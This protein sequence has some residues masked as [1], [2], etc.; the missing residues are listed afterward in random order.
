[1]TPLE[2]LAVVLPSPESGYYCTAELSTKKKEHKFT[3]N[4]EELEQYAQ[5]WHAQKKDVYFALAAFEQAGSREADNATY[6]RSL[7]IDMDG[8]ASKKE[9]A[10]SLTAFMT[11]TGLDLLGTPYIVASGGGLHVY[12][13]FDEDVEISRWK[14]LAE[15]LKRLCKQEGMR[16]DMAVTA[17]AARVLRVPDT[18]NFKKKYETPR[19]VRLLTEG[20]VFAFND[21][22]SVIFSQLQVPVTQ[23]T[24]TA[25]ALPGQRPTSVTSSSVPTA[26]IQNSVTKFKKILLK[27]KDGSGCGQLQ[28][29]IENASEDDMEPIWRGMLSWAKVCDD[30]PKACI[31]LS[32][33]HPYDEDRMNQKLAQI[34]GPYSCATMD[35]LNPGICDKCQHWGKITN[36]LLWGRDTAVTTEA[37]VVE[38]EAADTADTTHVLRPEPPSGFAYGQRGGVFMERSEPDENG[39][40]IKKQVMILPYDFFPVDILRTHSKHEVHFCAV[41]NKELHEVLLPQEAMASRSDTIKHLASANVMASFGMGNDKNLYDYVRACVEKLSME[42][43]PVK[44][45]ASYGWQDDDT[46]V[47]ANKIFQANKPPVL[48]PMSGLEN[49]TNNTRPTGSLDAWRDVINLMIRRQLWDHLAVVLAGAG[50]ALMRFTGLFGATVHCTSSES[51]TG[52]SFA[53]DTAASIW[54]HPVHYRT[55]AGTSPV[56][57]QQRLGLLRSLPLVTD[58]ITTNNRQ[59]FE[60]F[61]AFLFSMSEGRGKERM[62]SGTNRERVNLSVWASIALMSSNRPA[63]D[64][65]AGAR[66]H[67]SEGEL[68]R[69]IE[70]SMDQ[71]LSWTADEI[72]I[73]KSLQNNYAVAGEALAQWM[74]DNVDY[75]RKVVPETVARM[76]TEYGAPNDER[77]WMATAGCAVAAGIIFNSQHAGIVDIPLKEIISSYGRQISSLRAS[78]K[79]GKRTAEDVLNTYI[80]EYQGKFVI[81]KFGNKAHPSAM[82]GDGTSVDKG[83]TRTQ[84]MGR[85]EHGV[86]EGF[87]DF[88]IEERLMRTFCSNMSFSYSTFKSEIAN[89]FLTA[90]INK[91]DMLAKTD[92]P[93]MRVNVMRISRPANAIDDA[94][95]EPVSVVSD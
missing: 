77:Y 24:T 5:T 85:V 58:E 15:S 33:L 16:I 6:M 44:V 86:N 65:L 95:L 3:N 82:F 42:R 40:M 30:G 83:T 76:Y 2:F 46:F 32:Q 51:G 10:A 34:K 72:E 63:V 12:W 59:D 69:L 75:L 62:E 47:F 74:V 13:P 19:P 20:D 38:V 17:D 84:V 18:T 1:M 71:K 52:K 67:S 7:F 21:L 39:G 56:A 53:L 81:V 31:W 28:H 54:G 27:T 8:Y 92:G 43:R 78:I 90:F 64:Y 80:Q 87:I 48:V 61:P 66:A 36:P 68:R 25:L 9:A 57:M 93:P 35:N 94:L 89:N 29:Y 60:W 91:K 45:P 79:G 50:S 88:F 73:I 4:L 41:R 23:P 55:G 49:I 26:L 37:V 14:P 70:F 11:K 22:A